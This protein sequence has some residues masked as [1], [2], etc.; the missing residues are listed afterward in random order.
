M[1]RTSRCPIDADRAEA[2]TREVMR[3]SRGLWKSARR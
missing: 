1:V 2:V 3:D